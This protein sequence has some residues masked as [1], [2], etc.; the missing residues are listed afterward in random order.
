M[1]II[2]GIS[3]YDWLKISEI[4]VDAIIVPIKALKHFFVFINI[5]VMSL[6]VYFKFV[7]KA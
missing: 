6:W 3:A 5:I 1:F 7:V 2:F 4:V